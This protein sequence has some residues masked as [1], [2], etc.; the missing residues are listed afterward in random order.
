LAYY[1]ETNGFKS[2]PYKIADTLDV[3]ECFLHLRRQRFTMH[4]IKAVSTQKGDLKR[5]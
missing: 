4:G 1:T 5:D 3:K 2:K